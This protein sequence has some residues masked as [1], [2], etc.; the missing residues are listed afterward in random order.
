MKNPPVYIPE[1]ISKCFMIPTESPSH[2]CT[3]SHALGLQLG[4]QRAVLGRIQ[5]TSHWQC[6]SSRLTCLLFSVVCKSQH[7]WGGV[8]GRVVYRSPCSYP[9]QGGR[10]WA[11]GGFWGSCRGCSSGSQW[12]PSNES[13]LGFPPLLTCS[14][15]ISSQINNLNAN[16][17]SVSTFEE[18]LFSFHDFLSLLLSIRTTGGQNSPRRTRRTLCSLLLCSQQTSPAVIPAGLGHMCQLLN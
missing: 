13:A 14:L 4:S 15:G 17:I 5:G 7:P 11:L 2:G 18:T 12:A 16:F 9:P 10:F 8:S 1:K 3:V 6:L